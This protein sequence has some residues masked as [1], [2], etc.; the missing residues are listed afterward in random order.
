[1]SQL[2]PWSEL[3]KHPMIVTHTYRCC[4]P[5]CGVTHV[6]EIPCYLHYEVLRQ[7]PE[8]W[9]ECFGA[10]ICPKHKVHCRLDKGVEFDL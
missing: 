6:D 7:L 4:V 5:D 3:V 9:K 1:M 2:N 10:A 8:G